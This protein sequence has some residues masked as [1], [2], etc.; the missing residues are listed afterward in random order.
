M[1]FTGARVLIVEDQFLL[2]E[3][4]R[5]KL[6]TLGATVIGPTAQVGEALEYLDT[7]RVDAAI[8]DIYLA[9]EFVF[10]VAERLQ[11]MGI[12]FVFA[13]AYSTKIIPVRFE[14]FL[15]CEKPIELEEIAQ[16]LFGPA[17]RDH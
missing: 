7:T 17:R 6:E 16:A 12:P 15:L 4:T 8:L 5:Q 2:A 1:K 9:G 11:D 3:E 14:G 13:S 10:P